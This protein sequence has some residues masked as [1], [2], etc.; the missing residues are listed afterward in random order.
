MFVIAKADVCS[1]SGSQFKEHRK[2]TVSHPK[3]AM[4]NMNAHVCCSVEHTEQNESSTLALPSNMKRAL[5]LKYPSNE[6][7]PDISHSDPSII[8]IPSCLDKI[9]TRWF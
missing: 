4:S 5:E 2:R 7:H 3:V 1:L 6:A 9:I 8:N